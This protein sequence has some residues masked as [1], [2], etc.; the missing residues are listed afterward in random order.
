MGPIFVTHHKLQTNCHHLKRTLYYHHKLRTWWGGGLYMLLKL[1]F[2][3]LTQF[4]IAACQE[5]QH[6]TASNLRI[7][8][9]T[10]ADKFHLLS[11][12]ESE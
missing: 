7:L 6:V 9:E 11:I 3:Y 12:T 10:F 1:L 5:W 2:D 4:I 8:V